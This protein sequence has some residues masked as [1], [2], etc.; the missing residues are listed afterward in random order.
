MTVNKWESAPAPPWDWRWGYRLHN[1]YWSYLKD[2]SEYAHWTTFPLITQLWTLYP[3]QTDEWESAMST[4]MTRWLLDKDNVYKLC[5]HPLVWHH[6]E[7]TAFISQ[8]FV[9]RWWYEHWNESR[10]VSKFF[11]VVP[12]FFIIYSTQLVKCQFVPFTNRVQFDA[13]FQFSE[14]F[15][16]K[17]LGHTDI[18]ISFCFW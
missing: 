6:T 15:I 1:T 4:L 8:A 18:V 12:I 10:T 11:Y 2:T 9:V 17:W 5:K 7:T 16:Y 13:V 3:V 14:W